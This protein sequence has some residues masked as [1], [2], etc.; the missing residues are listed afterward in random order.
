M[1]LFFRIKVI[2]VISSKDQLYVYEKELLAL[3]THS[4]YNKYLLNT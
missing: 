3:N 4:N 1:L 2:V